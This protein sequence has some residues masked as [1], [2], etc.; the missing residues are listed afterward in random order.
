MSDNK[1]A[2]ISG[3]AYTFASFATAGMAFLTTPIFTRLMSQTDFGAFNNFTSWQSVLTVII[4]LNL[5]ATFISARF[6]YKNEFES[7]VYSMI[8]FTGVAILIFL[9][10]VNIWPKLFINALNMPLKYINLLIIYIFFSQTVGIFQT[11]EQFD[12]KYKSSILVGIIN[13][14]GT[15][16]ISILLVYILNDKLK[17]R[18]IGYTIPTI[19]IGAILIFFIVREGKKIRVKHLKYALPI[20]LP[21][22]PHMLS[23]SLLN[24]M[25]RIMINKICGNEETALYSLAYTCSSIVTVLMTS[26]NTA[27]SPWLARKLEKREYNLITKFSYVYILTFIFLLLGILLIAPEILFILG[28]KA[29][30]EAVFVMPPVITGCAMQMMYTMHVN[31]EQFNRKTIGMAIASVIAAI[32]NYILNYIFIPIYGYIAAAYTTYISYLI[33]LLLH[34]YLVKK[35]KVGKIYDNKFILVII[36]SLSLI[37]LLFNGLYLSDYIRYI[38]ILIYIIMFLVLLKKEGKNLVKIFKQ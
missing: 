25:D 35:I 34:I 21:F 16:I 9:F 32:S 7:Y 13:S 8:A 31:I 12:F 15:A 27:Y 22:I 20:C 38:V 4:S 19:L 30:S 2:V 3:I 37:M 14:I 6:D 23:L 26:M 24:S 28:G 11:K 29:Y 18:I 17:G 1:K 36:L 5:S 10:V 33:L